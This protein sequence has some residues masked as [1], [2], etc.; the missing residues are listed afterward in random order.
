MASN[1]RQKIEA[2]FRVDPARSPVRILLTTDAA[3]E[4]IDLPSHGSQLMHPEMPSNPNRIDIAGRC[5]SPPEH[6]SEPRP[7]LAAL[8]LQQAPPRRC[9]TAKRPA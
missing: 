9:N 4:G 8:S 6:G 7:A 5:L 2:A 1:L 3:C